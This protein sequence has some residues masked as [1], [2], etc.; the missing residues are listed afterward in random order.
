MN[1]CG[2]IRSLYKFTSTPLHLD[3]RKRPDFLIDCESPGE[4][5]LLSPKQGGFYSYK[6]RAI[7]SRHFTIQVSFTTPM[8][9]SKILVFFASV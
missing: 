6:P 1:P 7:A 3:R 5:P 4:D 8:F 2:L 9:T